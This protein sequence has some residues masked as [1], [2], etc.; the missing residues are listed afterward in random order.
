M[1]HLHQNEQA[2]HIEKEIDIRVNLKPTKSLKPQI[3]KYVNINSKS[4]YVYPNEYF[5]YYVTTCP[6]SH[7]VSK[8][9]GNRLANH[10]SSLIPHVATNT[11]IK[12]LQDFF[13]IASFFY[14]PHFLF[15]R[16]Q[17]FDRNSF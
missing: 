13:L 8:S 9:N 5:L 6:H 4:K 16:L 1:D 15:D 12:L 11:F 10:V 2:H 7:I 17:F 14:F 3:M